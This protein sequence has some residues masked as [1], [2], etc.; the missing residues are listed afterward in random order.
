MPESKA[1]QVRFK[2]VEKDVEEYAKENYGD[3]FSLAV[4]ELI[5][6]GLKQ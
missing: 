1:R 4:R 3:N 6:K 2:E 5:K